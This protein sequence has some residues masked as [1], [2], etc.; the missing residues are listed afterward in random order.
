M[1]ASPRGGFR[2]AYGHP[3]RCS[4]EVNLKGS[5]G[6]A[7]TLTLRGLTALVKSELGE[8]GR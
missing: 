3:P 1:D 6:G 4:Q 7:T 2:E 5:L 8:V